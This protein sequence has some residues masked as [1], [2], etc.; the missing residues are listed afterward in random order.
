MRGGPNLWVGVAAAVLA[1]SLG[2]CGDSD[3]E[4]TASETTAKSA[5]KAVTDSA[6]PSYG[7]GKFSPEQH[8][9]S[10]GGSAQIKGGDRR[11][12]DYGEEAESSERESAALVLHNFLDARADLD[13]KAACSFLA[14][15]TRKALEARA[16]RA[17]GL[18]DKSCAGMLEAISG[19]SAAMISEAAYADVISLRVEGDKGFIIFSEILPTVRS[20]R[21]VEKNGSWKVSSATLSSIR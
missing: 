17:E 5:T 4:S 15:D 3:S 16:A 12:L 21:M 19:A 7:E 18:K 11:V 14:P 1:I 13:W 2:A 9:D 20:M 6:A 10:G 8:K